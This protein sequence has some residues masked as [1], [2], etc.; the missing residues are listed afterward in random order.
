MLLAHFTRVSVSIRQPNLIG[1]Y[2]SEV[3][4]HL[5]VYNTRALFIAFRLFVCSASF[6]HQR[7]NILN[8]NTRD[9]SFK[10]HTWFELYRQCTPNIHH[11]AIRYN[12]TFLFHLMKCFPIYRTHF[13]LIH[14]RST[15][16]T[17]DIFFCSLLNFNRKEIPISLTSTNFSELVMEH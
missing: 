7:I 17:A 15:A 6:L 14:F 11:D 2:C 13:Q 3:D 8:S 10:A 4:I 12:Y 16:D 1:S 5:S 9:N